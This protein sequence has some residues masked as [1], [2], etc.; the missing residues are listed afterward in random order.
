MLGSV[1][2]RSAWS[3]IISFRK[4]F[5]EFSI[6]SIVYVR[7]IRIEIRVILQ[8]IRDLLPQSVAK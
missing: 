1:N 4:Q 2:D 3:I 6:A 8:E 7:E 5:T